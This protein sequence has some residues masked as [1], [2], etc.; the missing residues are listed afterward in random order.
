MSHFQLLKHIIDF[1]KILCRCLPLNSTRKFSLLGTFLSFGFRTKKFI[2]LFMLARNNSETFG[3]M[4]M[5]FDINEEN[6]HFLTFFHLFLKSDMFHECVHAFLRVPRDFLTRNW[7]DICQR[8]KMSQNSCSTLRVAKVLS[9]TALFQVMNK[10]VRRHRNCYAKAT[11]LFS[12]WKL[13][14]PNL[15][16]SNSR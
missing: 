16:V 15:S 4:F 14:F 10:N 13:V 6:H 12:A 8:S 2:C 9:K 5:K 1:R 11:F 3:E 7:L